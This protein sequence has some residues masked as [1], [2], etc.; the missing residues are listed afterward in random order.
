MGGFLKKNVM[1][2][3]TVAATELNAKNDLESNDLLAGY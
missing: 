1:A 2:R 3:K